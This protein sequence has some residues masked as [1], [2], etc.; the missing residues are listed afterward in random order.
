MAWL[1][2]EILNKISDSIKKDRSLLNRIEV[3]FIKL[4]K[5][6]SNNIGLK[7]RSPYVTKCLSMSLGEFGTFPMSD[8]G[9][10]NG[11]I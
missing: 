6:K 4:I 10:H 3:S 5:T 8:S 9:L 2:T 7:S 11:I 1:E